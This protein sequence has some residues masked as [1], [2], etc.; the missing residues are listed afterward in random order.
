LLS[1]GSSLELLCH[2]YGFLSLDFHCLLFHRIRVWLL[3]SAAQLPASLA[4]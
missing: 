2:F 1:T 4:A 3:P